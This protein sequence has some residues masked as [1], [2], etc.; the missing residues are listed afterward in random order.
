MTPGRPPAARAARVSGALCAAVAAAA[1]LGGCAQ[2]DGTALAQQACHHV[3]RSIAL[4]RRAQAAGSPAT[5]A[6]DRHDAQA[7]L[8]AALPLASTA[9]GQAWQYQALMSTLAES[10]HLPEGLLV[11]ALTQQCE[12]AASGGAPVPEP[13]PTA[14]TPDTRPPPTGF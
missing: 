12:A 9:A 1:V 13:T 11:H 7:E 10:V 4:Y 8:A 14:S 3:D 5:A 2:R 6:R